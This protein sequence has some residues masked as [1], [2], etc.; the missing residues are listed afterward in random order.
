MKPTTA[1]AISGGVDSMMTAYLLKQQG[2]RVSGIH[3]ITGFEAASAYT[4]DPGTEK[5]H[6]ILK[7]GEQLGIPVEIVDIRQEF[8]EKIVGYFCRTYHQGQ[9]PNPCMHCNPLI[10]FGTILAH[11]LKMGAQKLATGHYARIKRDPIGHY[12]LLK[13][14]DPQKDQSYFLARLTRQ[15]LAS[16]CFPLG[17]MKK[18]AIKRLAAQK[19]L[20]PVTQAESQDV[21]FIKDEG[22]AEFLTRQTG[23]DPQPGLIEN[24][25]GQVI[26][27]HRGLHLFTI[28]QRRGINCPAAEPY[29]VVR[30][31]AERNCLVVGSKHDLLSAEC[32]VIDINWINDKPVTPMEIQTRV[33][34]RSQETASTVIP[35]DNHTALVRFKVPQSA[36]TPGQGAVF[37]REDEVIGGGWIA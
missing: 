2:H 3:F 11:A 33:R 20:Y 26:G 18:T 30:L 32:R 31:D 22:Y 29:Y 23:F 34:Y 35:Q 27:E 6:T 15:Q 19:G 10:K 21:C 37:Y 13:G 5:N 17:E 25:S 4:R 12:H 36:L 28:G 1:V 24:V 16:A 7:I 9:T 14:L 8:Q